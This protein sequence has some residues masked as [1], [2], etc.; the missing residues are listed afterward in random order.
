MKIGSVRRIPAS[1]LPAALV[2]LAAL[3]PVVVLAILAAGSEGTFDART[4]RIAGNT[5]AL[6][7]L[8][9][10]GSVLIG[11]PLAL[12]TACSDLPGR[13]WWVGILASPLAIP[14]YVGA[15]AYFAGF[16]P[17]GEFDVIPGVPLPRVRGL[18]GA[19]WVMTIY[20]FP[21]VLLTVRASLCRL[22]ARMVDAARVMGLSLPGAL[23]RVVLPR[24]RNG[25]AAGALLV[26]LYTLSDFATPAILGLDTFTRAIFVEYNAF[27]LDRAALFSLQLMGL[28]V[29]V[30]L[31]ESR[32]RVERERP[33]RRLR[34]RNGPLAKVVFTAFPALVVL[35]ALG[36][37]L[38]ALGL[39]LI[40]DGV[41]SFDP[42]VA[43]H[44]TY[45]AALAAIAAILVALPVAAAATSGRLGRGFERIA[46]VGFG[47]PGIVMG[48]ALVYVGLQVEMLYQTVALLVLGY[49]L[50]FL[51]LALGAIRTGL[52]RMDAHLVGA[53][54]SLGAS[55]LEA[56]RRVTL[57]LLAPSLIAGGALVFLE[58][59]RELPLTL[60]LRPNEFETL[61]TELW[62]VYESGY[63]GRAAL[64]GLLLILISASV[65]AI[66]L[67]GERYVGTLEP[68][69]GRD[70]A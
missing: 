24:I 43:W 66:M 60:L 40:R 30:L 26:A 65:V 28:V 47:T 5:L 52:E 36:P 57:P 1:Y 51:P 59:M 42:V 37:P 46:S 31:L 38:G 20:T 70:H 49:V 21:F 55:P 9:V 11:V 39:W 8:T 19:A 25:I 33:G 50:R 4:L 3:A 34:W 27:G 14:S 13:R 29:L 17:G 15:F 10:A 64:P 63:F 69:A 45:P 68:G 23:V 18:P 67:K 53:A 6:T 61:T 62:R 22:D 32:V 54:R 2:A 56:H 41:G 44:S 58:A 12:L 48:T 35:A 16:G 7:A